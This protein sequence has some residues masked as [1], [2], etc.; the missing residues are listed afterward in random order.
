MGISYDEILERMS[1]EFELQSGYEAASQSD[2]GIRLKLLAGEIFALSCNI[3]WLKKEMFPDTA[4]GEMLDKHGEQ[5]GIFRERGNKAS[6][7]IAVS[8]DVPLDYD[9]VIPAGTVFTTSDGRLDFVSTEEAVIYRGTSLCTVSA[10]AVKSG[11]QYNVAP[12]EITTVVTYFSIGVSVSN[13]GAFRGGS[14]DETDESLRKRIADRIRNIPN[15]VNKAFFED[16]IKNVEG[17]NSVKLVEDNATGLSIYLCGRGSGVD[18]DVIRAVRG[19]IDERKCIGYNYSVYSSNPFQQDV[20]VRITVRDGFVYSDVSQEVRAVIDE[21]FLDAR[22]GQGLVL[23]ELGSR[24]IS[25]PG[26]ENYEF[27]NMTDRSIGNS[28]FLAPGTITIERRQ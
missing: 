10:E 25:V 8:V 9:I 17:V 15:G 6:G 16:M 24:I 23:A 20:T 18:M 27:V 19:L 11:R 28:Q 7:N 22:A 14:E 21:F 2:I 3:E 4:T 5:R 12:G 1:D 13:S 26:V